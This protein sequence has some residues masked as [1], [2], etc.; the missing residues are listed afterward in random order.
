[1]SGGIPELTVI[2]G[3]EPLV[4]A[5]PSGVIPEHWPKRARRDEQIYDNG[6]KHLVQT[7]R[8]WLALE[9]NARPYGRLLARFGATGYGV[10]VTPFD[11]HA[12]STAPEVGWL[13]S[14]P[15]DDLTLADFVAEVAGLPNDEA[16]EIVSAAHRE[17]QRRQSPSV[18][19]HC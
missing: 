8:G 2:A 10:L 14:S 5:R 4:R 1:M 16:E 19:G 15:R 6:M 13:S 12:W 7:S 17:W 11:H 18:R 9:F 3:I